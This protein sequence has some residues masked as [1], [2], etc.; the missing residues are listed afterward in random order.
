RARGRGPAPPGGP[1]TPAVRRRIP[2]AAMAVAADG[3][4][5]WYVREDPPFG[6]VGHVPADG[7]RA[8]EVRAGPTPV[9]VDVGPEAVSVLEGIPTG[10][11]RNGLPRL[12]A[13]E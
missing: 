5:A 8:V 12:S 3:A 9:D 13:L 6:F 2:V 1:A 4:D 11:Q 10:D 7:A